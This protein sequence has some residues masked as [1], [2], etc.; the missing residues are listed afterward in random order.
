MVL[1]WHLVYDGIG[2]GL[3]VIIVKNPR[4]LIEKLLRKAIKS[5]YETNKAVPDHCR[6]CEES[7]TFVE[8]EAPL[9]FKR[10]KSDN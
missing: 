5:I 6:F 3:N 7:K 8:A 10:T 9:N 2:S 4:A 1:C